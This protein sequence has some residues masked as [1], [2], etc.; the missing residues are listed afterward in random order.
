LTSAHQ[1]DIKTSKKIL[2]WSKEKIKK[3]NF[4]KNAFKTQK[5]TVIIR[6]KSTLLYYFNALNYVV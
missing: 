3:L 6:K 2:I 4:F 1:N 5:Q